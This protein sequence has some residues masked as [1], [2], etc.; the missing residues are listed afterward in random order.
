MSKYVRK[1]TRQSW[2]EESMTGA[3]TE[4]MEGRMGYLK[5][6]RAF[7]IPQSTLEDRAKKIRSGKSVEEATQKGLGRCKPVF[8]AAL[9]DELA[10]HVLTMATKVI[11]LRGKRQV[12]ALVSAERGTLVTLEICMSASGLGRCKPVFSA[13]LEDELA[14]HVLTMATKVIELRGKRKVGALVS[15]ERGTLVT[16]EICMSA[17]GNYMAPFFY[18]PTEA[19]ET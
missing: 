18:L 4:V 12:R 8:S 10:S 7:G 14:S 11:E 17:S 6:S 2:S 16:L 19:S 5:A 15:A 3:I 9:E 1:T 13:A